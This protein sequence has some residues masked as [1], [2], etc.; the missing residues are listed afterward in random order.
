MWY[1]FSFSLINALLPLCLSIQTTTTNNNLVAIAKTNILPNKINILSNIKS[2]Q[3]SG[4][5][6]IWHR[7]NLYQS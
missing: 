5:L 7:L 6:L 4:I 3:F 2:N 1:N